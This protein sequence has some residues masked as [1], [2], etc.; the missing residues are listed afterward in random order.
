MLLINTVIL[1]IPVLI[2]FQ[3]S[4][5]VIPHESKEERGKHDQKPRAEC[6]WVLLLLLRLHALISART[7][8]QRN[9]GNIS[10]QRTVVAVKNPPPAL[11][12]SHTH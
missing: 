3:R 2:S 11:I 9:T 4:F 1:I 10:S 8:P 7:K 12:A 5:D 6:S